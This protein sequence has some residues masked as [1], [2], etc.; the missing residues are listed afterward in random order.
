MKPDPEVQR[1]NRFVP[2]ILPWVVAAA[3][4]ALYLLTLSHWITATSLPHFAQVAGYQWQP[5]L[6]SPVYFV[7]TWPLKQLPSPVLPLALNLFSALC[8]TLTL[9]LLARAVALLPHDRTHLQRSRERSIDSRLTI[10]TAWLPVVFAV[11]ACGLNF[12]FWERATA[13]G[14]EMLDQLLF[15]YV[16]RCLLE[17]R[18]N[19]RDSWML[20]AV[21]VYAL[22]M[23]ESWLMVFLLPAFM[24]SVIWVMGLRFF[25]GRFLLSACALALAGLT[26]YLLLP[27]CAWVQQDPPIQFW[28]TLKFVLAGQKN[29]IALHWRSVRRLMVLAAIPSLLPMLIIGLRFGSSFGDTSRLGTSLTTMVFHVFHGAF[30]VVCAWVTLDPPFSFSESSLGAQFLPVQFPTALSIGYFSGYFLLI[31]GARA[32]ISGRWR[33]TLKKANLGIVAGVWVLAFLVV[34]ILLHRN[35][36]LIRANNGRVLQRYAEALVRGLP[37]QT[38]VLLSDDPRRLW[39]AQAWLARRP[40]A[41]QPLPV[42]TAKL[43]VP[44]YHRVLHRQSGGFWPLP[45]TNRPLVVDSLTLIQRMVQ[46]VTQREVWYLHPSFGYY[47]ECLYAEPH[48]PVYRC[49]CYPTNELFPPPMTDD[50]IRENLKFWNEVVTTDVPGLVRCA[51]PRWD[52]SSTNFLARALNTIRVTPGTFADAL[53]V[54]EF[55]SRSL[56]TW[57]VQLQ[58]LGR[59]EEAGEVFSHAERLNPRNVVAHINGEFNR[60]L[61]SGSHV[62]VTITRAI[63]DQ[64]GVYKEWSQVLAANG[65]FDEPTF[66]YE[67]GRRMEQMSHYRQA[68][69]EFERVRTLVPDDVLSRLSLGHIYDTCR[70]PDR[71]LAVLE[72]IKTSPQLPTL[73]TT[74]QTDLI[75]LEASARFGLKDGEAADR[76][77][78]NAITRE[79]TNSYLL[80]GSLRFYVRNSLYTNAV[81]LLDFQLRLDPNNVDTLMKR[82]I[83]GLQAGMYDETIP[84]FNLLLTL[85]PT[86][87]AA[88]LNRAIAHL[89]ADH[90]EDAARD[91]RTLAMVFTNAF[92]IHYGLGEIAWR[93]HNTNDAIRCYE[94]YLASAPTNTPEATLVRDRLNQ[95]KRAGP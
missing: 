71:S 63:E 53:L 38:A 28:P 40:S 12:T 55:H 78:W 46:Q 22:G 47:F 85:Q 19:G 18:H 48:G 43:L 11:L 42:N 10:R 34:G 32:R 20:R 79:P 8:A 31:F 58:R 86:N 95:L 7:L 82:G 14:P 50:L 74:N 49:S 30:L 56:N 65:P 72:E 25:N 1:E 92:R 73:T 61:R 87:H 69:H 52:A 15:A 59:P 33:E 57:G 35:L 13:G 66:C 81:R 2:A 21:V 36:P 5:T 90:L 67:E 76:L 37:A 26:L 41:P 16:V 51:I 27:L 29:T 23:T 93:Q 24:V 9:A 6:S 68:I 77:L 64:F 70:L 94:L 84:T 45:P 4:F 3:G 44:E 89:Q 17:F 75:I 60:S 54:A 88:L 39:L 91:Y 83:V 80:A 62:S